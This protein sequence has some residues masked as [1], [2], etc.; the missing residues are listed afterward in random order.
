MDF[1][2]RQWLPERALV[3]C[4]TYIVCLV[5]WSHLWKL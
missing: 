2:L 3:L 4:H 1:P 5:F